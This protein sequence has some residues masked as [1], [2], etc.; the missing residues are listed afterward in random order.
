MIPES[1]SRGKSI[2]VSSRLAW[3]HRVLGQPGLHGEILAKI[4]KKRQREQQAKNTD[5]CYNV[6]QKPH[7]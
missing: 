3:L 1:R 5:E 4:K 2:S 7:T 6:Q